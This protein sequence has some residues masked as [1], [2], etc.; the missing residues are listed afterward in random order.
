[1]ISEKQRGQHLEPYFR[2][3]LPSQVWWNA[4]TERFASQG[5]HAVGRGSGICPFDPVRESD[6]IGLPGFLD[7]GFDGSGCG[8]ELDAF[9]AGFEREL[10]GRVGC[11]PQLDVGFFLDVVGEV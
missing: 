2:E 9:G 6:G 8:V 11:L 4:T 10:L 1:M 3:T 7:G 5:D